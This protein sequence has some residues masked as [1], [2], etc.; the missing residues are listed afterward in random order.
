MT[1]ATGDR[2]LKIQEVEA[3]IGL[4]RTSIYK[5][6][7]EG[8]FPRPYKPTNYASRW[9]DLEISIWMERQRRS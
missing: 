6:I 4:G 8:T 3:R 1:N 7:Q 9:S 5:L 2:F